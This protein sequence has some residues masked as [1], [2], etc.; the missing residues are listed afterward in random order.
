MMNVTKRLT[1]ALAV[2][3]LVVS[4]GR[5]QSPA[6]TP[7]DDAA[8]AAVR[9]ADDARIAAMMKP[10]RDKLNA[11]FSDDLRYAHSTGVVDTKTSFVE[12][13]VTGKSKYLGYDHKDRQVTL[14]AKGIALVAGQARVQAESASGKMDS[15]L[16]YLSVWREE[17]GQW[18]FLAW[19]SCRIPP[20]TN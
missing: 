1:L 13:L 8:I 7:A 18:R 19:Q 20:A 3:L 6:T 4:T 11:I 9:A 2:S 15:V 16:S 14:P 10:D 17:N 12:I 5:A